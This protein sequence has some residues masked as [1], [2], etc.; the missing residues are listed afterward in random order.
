MNQPVKAVDL[1]PA[2]GIRPALLNPAISLFG[3]VNDQ[4]FERFQ[5]Q[6]SQ[7]LETDAQEIAM[8]LS[9]TGGD[10]ETARR[11]ALEINLFEKYRERKLLFFG[12][13]FVYSAGV[14]IMS[15]FDRENRYL[16]KDCL[17]LIH[18]RRLDKTVHY[19]GPLSSNVQ[20]AE[21]ML[22]E[23]KSGIEL[24]RQGFRALA[25]GSKI[26]PEEVEKR[27][28]RNWYACAEEA[29]DCGLIKAVI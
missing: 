29:L 12:K 15:A 11:I 8:E 26:S 5:F 3:S 22:G 4:M 27:A 19:F 28:V 17:L 9:T 13:S 6:L 20:I 23:L 24:E 25:E 21:E 7:A 2:Q 1:T 16:S 18:A 14:T 10:A